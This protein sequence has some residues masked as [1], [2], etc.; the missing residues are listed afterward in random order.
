M[1]TTESGIY[2][3]LAAE[4]TAGLVTE[5]DDQTGTNLLAR[6]HDFNDCYRP[7]PDDMFA[8]RNLSEKSVVT[9]VRIIGDRDAYGNIRPYHED[10]HG[11]EYEPKELAID[12]PKA[13]QQ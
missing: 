8:A 11:K 3:D 5:G 6:P 2:T 1:S 12:T 4:I 9:K 10:C 13:L 7:T